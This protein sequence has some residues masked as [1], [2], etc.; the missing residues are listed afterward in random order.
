M[1]NA[2]TGKDDHLLLYLAQAIARAT[3]IRFNIAFLMESG[4]RLIAPHL[5]EACRHGAEIKILTGRYMSV[6]EPSAIYY[7]ID[8]LDDKAKLD[9]MGF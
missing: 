1:H 8:K 9:Q 5:Q 7:L 3:K 2:I 4:V 6:T